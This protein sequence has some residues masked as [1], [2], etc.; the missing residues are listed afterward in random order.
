VDA[1]ARAVQDWLDSECKEFIDAWKKAWADR[2]DET[3]DCLYH[4]TG[5]EGAIGIL[6]NETI[7][8]SDARYLNDL[9]E[10]SYVNGI[11]ACVANELAGH[12]PRDGLAHAFLDAACADLLDAFT[13]RCSSQASI[14]VA[15]FC[16]RGDLLSQ[17]RAYTASGQG[18][19]L[20][21]EPQ[22]MRSPPGLLLR[23]VFYEKDDQKALVREV[24]E[25]IASG[26]ARMSPGSA[27]A[28]AVTGALLAAGDALAEPA[29][30]FKNPGFQEEREWR[31]VHR[32]IDELHP[33]NAPLHFRAT[34]T[35]MVPYVEL[36]PNV[37]ED[38][39]LPF[40]PKFSLVWGV[41]TFVYG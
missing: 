15:S 31:L 38:G 19:A 33:A 35:A 18:Y 34:A 24:L 12:F 28:Y 41:I 3:P 37:D 6:T 10:L 17:W 40:K 2:H 25:F 21:F 23:R 5:A 7:W 9:S 20:G 4:Y 36:S 13:G 32:V 14:Y 30:C 22:Q 26:L 16:E 1:D 8:A 29:L 39:R 11:L 27:N